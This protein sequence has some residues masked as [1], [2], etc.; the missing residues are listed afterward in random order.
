MQNRAASRLVSQEY[1]E[2][3]VAHAA[4]ACR[5]ELGGPVTCG[6]VFATPHYLPHLEDFLDTLRLEGHIPTLVGA[7]AHGVIAQRVEQEFGP[8]FSLLL[9]SL[10]DAKV[11]PVEIPAEFLERELDPGELL[12]LTDCAAADMSGWL[13]LLDG[14]A[15]VTEDF[16]ATWNRAYPGVPTVGGLAGVPQAVADAIEAE[17]EVQPPA[18]PCLILDGRCAT[19]S[20]VLLGLSGNVRVETIVSQGCRP[21]GFPLTITSADHNLV[22][23]MGSQTAYEVLD[24]VFQSLNDREKANAR[25]NLLA[26]LA[27]S[28]YVEDFKRGD[29]LIR[30][31]LGAD[32]SSGA[33]VLGAAARVGQTMQYQMRDREAAEEDLRDMCTAL[34]ERQV[35]PCAA[36]IFSCVGRGRRLFGAPHH[37]ALEIA[38]RF[39][40]PATC[41]FF[42]DGE[43]GPVTGATH[44]H[45]FTASIALIV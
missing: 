10:P 3:A 2:E 20:G 29:F 8:A 17:A 9:L 15:P 22:F 42:C 1:S 14:S 38:R 33:V 21:I 45:T 31:I 43:V 5:E 12:E 7:C 23:K 25:G 26:G 37:D 41:G 32:P 28:E 27:G 6:I 44:L 16:M 39:Q 35:E 11:T 30:S 36:L 34:V 4:R 24:H 13:M 40:D 19:G 18:E